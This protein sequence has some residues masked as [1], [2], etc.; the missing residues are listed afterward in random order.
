MRRRTNKA[1]EDANYWPW[2]SANS[3]L[4]ENLDYEVTPPW[5]GISAMLVS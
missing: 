1:A 3:G 2:P 4:D 5:S